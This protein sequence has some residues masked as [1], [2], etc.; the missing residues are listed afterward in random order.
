MMAKKPITVLLVEEKS[1][2]RELFRPTLEML[3]CEVVGEA[4]TH[5]DAVAQ[6]R[7]FRP[8]LVLT[9]I[10][11]ALGSGLD[12]LRDIRAIDPAALL[13]MLSTHDDAGTRKTCAQLGAQGFIVKN[14]SIEDFIDALCGYLPTSDLAA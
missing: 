1:W 6:Y 7:Q 12:V 4:G 3:G 14:R 8:D 5:Q 13:V 9:N 10:R 2:L 11:L